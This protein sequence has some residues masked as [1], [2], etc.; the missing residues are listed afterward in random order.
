MNEHFRLRICFA[1][2]GR[3]RWLSHLELV[4][5]MERLIRRSGLPYAV[6]QGFSPHMRYAPGPALPVGTAGLNEL[7]DVWLTAY[8]PVAEAKVMLGLASAGLI[9]ISG[10][11]YVANS[12]K[13]LQATHTVSSYLVTVGSASLGLADMQSALDS[14]VAREQLELPYKKET[15]QYDLTACIVEPPVVLAAGDSGG[16]EISCVLRDLGQGVLRPDMLVSAALGDRGEV[17]QV[18]RISVEKP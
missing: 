17:L 2:T 7:F 3:L 6:S 18:T 16:F 12:E 5:A 1:K 13:G 8:V 11:D 9:A 15:R 14:L 10:V 4:R